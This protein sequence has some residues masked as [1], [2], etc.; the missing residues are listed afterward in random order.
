MKKF[1]IYWACLAIVGATL[2]SSA[3]L[4]IADGNLSLPVVLQSLGGVIMVVASVSEL[5]TDS[6]SEFSVGTVG[7][8]AVILGTVGV[9]LSVIIGSL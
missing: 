7:Y 2:G 6:P 4:M 1:Y 8:W 9:L 5:L 3:V